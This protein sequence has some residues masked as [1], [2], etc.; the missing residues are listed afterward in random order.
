MYSIREYIP[1]G[2]TSRRFTLGSIKLNYSTMVWYFQT[3]TLI[4]HQF[5][6]GTLTAPPFLAIPAT[7]LRQARASSF[8]FF[9]NLLQFRDVDL[10]I[11]HEVGESAR[12][13]H[14]SR[15]I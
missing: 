5:T 14:G 2:V 4:F 7:G 13:G 10:T 11:I 8:W 6:M 15:P 12:K 1:L 9:L 3:N